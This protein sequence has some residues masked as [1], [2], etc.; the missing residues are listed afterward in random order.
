MCRGREEG[1][2]AS[3]I[4]VRIYCY[5]ALNPS[6]PTLW[7]P[8]CLPLPLYICACCACCASADG[9][10]LIYSLSSRYKNSLLLNFA[11]QK[12]LRQPGREREVA[13]VGGSL[14]GYFGVFHRLTATRLKDVAASGD[15]GELQKLA[16]EL[17]VCWGGGWLTMY[18]WREGNCLHACVRAS[19]CSHARCYCCC[20]LTPPPSTHQPTHP[21][22][23]TSPLPPPP[24]VIP[25]SRR[26]AAP[27][28]MPTYTRSSC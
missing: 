15:E 18:V 28:S 10:A 19:A 2:P 14:V 6:A 12:I 1:G 4:V 26:A 25:N 3:S 24:R 22:P 23:H 9:R 8:F 13:A 11:I 5:R 7:M 21:H 16:D 17:K 27:A 20:S